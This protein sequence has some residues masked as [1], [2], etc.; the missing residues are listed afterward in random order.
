MPDIYSMSLD[1]L[2]A[3]ADAVST[4][5]AELREVAQMPEV[6]DDMLRRR[7]ES[8]G[9]ERGAEW[10]APDGA[11]NAYPMGWEVTYDDRLW[12]SLLHGNVWEP[13]VS[14]WREVSADEEKPPLWVQ[15][16]GA[17][18]AYQK[19]DRVTFDEHVWFS[20]VDANVW[21]PA[22]YGWEKEQ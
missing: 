12:I 22:V 19:G 16:T 17:H 1:E 14:G 8:Q 7:R 21:S 11:H 5:L 20:I 10:V 9:D 4:R 18:D 2:E 3:H 15:P 6:M 13:G